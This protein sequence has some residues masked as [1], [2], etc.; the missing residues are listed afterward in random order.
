MRI[1]CPNLEEPVDSLLNSAC[2]IAEI[3][4]FRQVAAAENLKEIDL[5]HQCYN[6]YVHNHMLERYT[7]EAKESGK[8]NAKEEKQAIQ[9]S[10]ERLSFFSCF[11]S[12]LV[13]ISCP[14]ASGC[15]KIISD[16]HSHSNDEYSSK[17]Q[18]YFIKNLPFHSETSNNFFRCLDKVMKNTNIAQGKS[19]NQSHQVPPTKHI[20]TLFPRVPNNIP[21]DFYNPEWF[22]DLQPNVRDLVAN[23]NSVAFL[24]K[25]S[26]MLQGTRNPDEKLRYKKF[27]E[28]YWAQTTTKYD[29]KYLIED[30]QDNSDIGNEDSN[31]SSYCGEE[32]DMLDTSGKDDE[33][34]EE[35][36]DDIAFI[37]ENNL[38]GVSG[39]YGAYT[40][41]KKMLIYKDDFKFANEWA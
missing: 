29:L 19:S 23:T 4:T 33:D 24:P 34:V 11:N 22:N 41:N 21:L 16:I 15:K 6:H 36:E 30:N 9:K 27:S 35:Q 2:Q 26:E 32:V 10:C 28:N 25:S 39:D 37:D 1:W 17:H 31:D 14:S 8:F 3:S 38:D 40:K 7:K 18:K 5:L 12:N 13:L 20:M